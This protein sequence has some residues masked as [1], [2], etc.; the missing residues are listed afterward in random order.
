MNSGEDYS[1]ERMADAYSY[2]SVRLVMISNTPFLLENLKININ[3]YS[4]TN[5]DMVGNS[6]IFELN[7]KN[8]NT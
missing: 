3:S 5:G 1:F 6:D 7:Q 8:T 2:D 4:D